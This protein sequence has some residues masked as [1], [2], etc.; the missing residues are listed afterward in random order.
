MILDRRVSRYGG[1]R[2]GVKRAA[3]C[4]GVG[5]DGLFGCFFGLFVCHGVGIRRSYKGDWRSVDDREQGMVGHRGG[6]RLL[7]F[8]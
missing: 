4:F 1:G 3:P 8:F 7:L 5:Y 2:T 6:R